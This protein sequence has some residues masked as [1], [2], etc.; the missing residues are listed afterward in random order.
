MRLVNNQKSYFTIQVLKIDSMI[1]INKYQFHTVIFIF[2]LLRIFMKKTLLT[3]LV[4]ISFIP[5]MYAQDTVP[6]IELTPISETQISAALILKIEG[7]ILDLEKNSLTAVHMR[8]LFNLYKNLC[9]PELN[10]R[11]KIHTDLSAQ[12]QKELKITEIF[13]KMLENKLKEIHSD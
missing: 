6:Q 4:F 3:Y 9:I 2:K 1:P 8:E 11:I 13:L 7:L 12:L 5:N 10:A